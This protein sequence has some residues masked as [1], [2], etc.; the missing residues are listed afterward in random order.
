MACKDVD[1]RFVYEMISDYWS[2]VEHGITPTTFTASENVSYA[3]CL[4]IEDELGGLVTF[5]GLDRAELGEDGRI[6]YWQA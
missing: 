2:L 6:I 5:K 3:D 4:R 1:E